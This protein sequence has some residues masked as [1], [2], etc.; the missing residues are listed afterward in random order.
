MF[1]V[2]SLEKEI[3]DPFDH[4][5]TLQFILIP[6]AFAML[7][8]QN[9]EISLDSAWSILHE[10][11]RFGDIIHSGCDLHDDNEMLKIIN[12][13]LPIVSCNFYLVYELTDVWQD[14]RREEINDFDEGLDPEP[15]VSCSH[16]RSGWLSLSHTQKQSQ[17]TPE[18]KATQVCFYL[19]P[20][21]LY[22]IFSHKQPTIT[23]FFRKQSNITVS[24][25][26]PNT[27]SNSKVC[28]SLLFSLACP[29]IP[30]ENS[31]VL[32]LNRCLH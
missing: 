8:Q 20:I 21:K 3:T 7:V 11:G 18:A 19:V 32:W 15:E 29:E 13:H 16:S 10:S 4:Q 24:A 27:R 2:G 14:H 23:A 5:Q 6:S 28:P 30:C 9:H 31:P 12:S 22:S 26:K 25:R 17:I 1:P